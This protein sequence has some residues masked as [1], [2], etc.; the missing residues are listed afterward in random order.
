[1]CTRCSQHV[2]YQPSLIESPIQ[3][4][5]QGREKQLFSKLVFQYSS[6]HL[7]GK[8]P[9][10]IIVPTA[11]APA[12]ALSKCK[13]L[14]ESFKMGFST[15]SFFCWFFITYYLIFSWSKRKPS[16]SA[17]CVYTFDK[18]T[19]KTYVLHKFT[20]KMYVYSRLQ[21]K[22]PRPTL[23]CS[24]V[25]SLAACLNS[26]TS[27]RY[28]R[29]HPDQPLEFVWDQRPSSTTF[30]QSHQWQVHPGHSLLTG[31]SHLI[32]CCTGKSGVWRHQCCLPSKS[33]CK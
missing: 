30:D 31:W 1:M 6:Y 8:K 9:R 26:P 2:L 27:A 11:P 10:L 23:S 19:I 24:S 7:P 20:L 17:K 5:C 16:R 14:K 25:R 18:I 29:S 21:N 33:F 28:G 22:N 4:T 32:G 12:P 15:P 3:L 13:S